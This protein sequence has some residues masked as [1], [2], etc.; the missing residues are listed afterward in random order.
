[1]RRLEALKE[2][3]FSGEIPAATPVSAPVTL[4]TPR[5]ESVTPPP[6]VHAPATQAP[7]QK[8]VAPG[9]PVAEEPVPER[10]EVPT[11]SAVPAA[12]EKEPVEEMSAETMVPE[13]E[14]E[15]PA[16]ESPKEETRAQP[17]PPT[18]EAAT[19]EV[20]QEPVARPFEKRDIPH[21]VAKLSNAPL[22][23]QVAQ[24]IQRVENSEGVLTL[25]FSTPFC[26]MRAQEE[27]ERFK[28]LINEITGY[29]GPIRFH[30]IENNNAD[31]SN[32]TE[33]RDETLANIAH[34]FRGEIVS[35]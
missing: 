18:R 20:K 6:P 32:D 9:E 30:A 35:R 12:T 14:G 10:A 7:A 34:L 8:S 5:Q 11:E 27:Q 33:E 16:A 28:S 2:E 15:E 19:E 29:R 1:M 21:L 22:L 3:I 26:R 24:S 23:S 25:H 17:E 13:P 4:Q 31:T